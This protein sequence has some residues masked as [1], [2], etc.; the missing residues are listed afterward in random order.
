MAEAYKIFISSTMNDLKDL[1]KRVADIITESENVPIMAENI[2]DIGSPKE[3]I[4]QKIDNC[5]CYL[6]IFD[7]RWGYIP[8]DDN[9]GKLSVTAR[10][11]ES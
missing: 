3:I 5:D 11:S 7:R 4:E 10:I 9:P 6:G 1:R 2:M 8:L